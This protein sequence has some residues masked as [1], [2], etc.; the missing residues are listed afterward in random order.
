MY[1]VLQ[2]GYQIYRKEK[3][4]WIV[5]LLYSKWLYWFNANAYEN[6][7]PF[8]SIMYGQKLIYS[9]G[10]LFGELTQQDRH[11]PSRCSRAR[12]TPNVQKTGI[13]QFPCAKQQKSPDRSYCQVLKKQRASGG[14]W[15]R[16][17]R[18]RQ[19]CKT[20]RL[21]FCQSLNH[22]AAHLYVPAHLRHLNKIRE[23]KFCI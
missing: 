12:K 7:L 10:H 14:G 4:K 16:L 22:V 8:I 2:S 3:I 15:A 5:K 23:A 17:S 21:W 6:D 20:Q 9:S 13:F 19:D 1:T 11:S 18:P